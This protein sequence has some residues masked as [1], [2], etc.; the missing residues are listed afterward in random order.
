MTDEPKQLTE[1]EKTHWREILQTNYLGSHDL[2]G[3]D[4]TV[5]IKSV[6]NEQVFCPESGKKEGRM[7]IAFEKAKKPWICNV[8]NAQTIES[9]HGKFI[10]DWVGKKITLTTLPVKAFGKT[11]DAVRVK[12]EARSL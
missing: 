12:K 5:T 6:T 1:Q 11:T 8:T 7:V 2:K 10:D 3:R 4:V 9:Q